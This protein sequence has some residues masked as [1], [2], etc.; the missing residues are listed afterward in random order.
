[1]ILRYYGTKY[2]D[3]KINYH[4]SYIYIYMYKFSKHVNF[5]DVTNPAFSRY[6]FED[7]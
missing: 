5:K 6:I 2:L 3:S 1:M 4:I 7:H